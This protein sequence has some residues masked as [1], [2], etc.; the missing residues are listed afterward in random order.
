MAKIYFNS[1]TFT[2]SRYRVCI[3]IVYGMGQ[4]CNEKITNKSA[5][6]NKIDECDNVYVIC[7]KILLKSCILMLD[8]TI[9]GLPTCLHFP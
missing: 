7:A 5:E 9:V 1:T 2:H 6:C 8:S 4:S 3:I